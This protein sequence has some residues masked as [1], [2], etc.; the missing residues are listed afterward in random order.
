MLAVNK[1]DLVGFD[2]AVFE[3]IVADFHAVL[4]HL[5]ASGGDRDPGRAR[6]TATTSPRSSTRMPWYQG[7][8]LLAALESAEPAMTGWH[9]P[10]RMPVQF[11]SRPGPRR[12]AAMPAPSPPAR[13]V[14]ATRW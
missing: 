12:S 4:G 7:T 8:S 6:A 3:H 5:R 9:R 2:Q 10:F 11:V 13:C 1:M 14:R